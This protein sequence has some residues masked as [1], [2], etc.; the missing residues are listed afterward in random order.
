MGPSSAGANNGGQPSGHADD[1]IIERMTPNSGLESST[2][3]VAENLG[4]G[5]DWTVTAYT[6]CVD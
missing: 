5:T 6:I 4:L 1:L 3:R 2:T